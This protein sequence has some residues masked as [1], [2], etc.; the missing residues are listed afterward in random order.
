MKIKLPARFEDI[1]LSQFLAWQEKP[2]LA[3][4]VDNWKEVPH[5]ATEQALNHIQSLVDG[6]LPKFYPIIEIKGTRYGFI[7][8]WDKF[9]TGEWIDTERYVN[10][11][12]V[13]AFLSILYRP[14]VDEVGDNYKIEPYEGKVHDLFSDIPASWYLG[15]TAF[16]LSRRNEYL[17]T[18][19]QSLM[20]Q[21][22]QTSSP[23]D[24][25]G[26]TSYSSWLVKMF[27]RLKK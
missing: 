22:S 14:I 4:F 12:N 7:N 25:V 11:N 19:E 3:I 17:Q 1:T 9:T 27:S 15:V 10:Q 21:A 13:M 26:M 5:G 6:A 20:E 2:S 8:E 18:L 24:G 23:N 16:F